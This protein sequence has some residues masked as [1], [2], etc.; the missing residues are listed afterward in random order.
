MPAKNSTL[1][2]PP[3]SWVSG[4]FQKTY[5]TANFPPKQSPF[6]MLVHTILSQ[7]TNDKNSG[8]AFQELQQTIPVTP[9]NILNTPLTE[10]QRLIK[11]AGLWRIK[12]QRIVEVARIVN[13][14]YNGCLEQLFTEP[15]ERIREGLLQFPGIGYKTADILLLFY[16]H[17][18]VLPLDVHCL[19]VTKRLGYGNGKNYEATRA[20]LE[21]G[22]SSDPEVYF[23][24]HTGLIQHGR[25]ICHARSP[26]CSRCPL[27][28]KCL[29]FPIVQP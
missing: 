29:S 17:L 7:H 24:F 5:G 23:Q 22:L 10:L 26:K 14:Q 12:S 8:R 28:T 11:S 9:Q 1:S 16:A 4:K 25:Q 21:Q 18:P 15:L 20:R 6:A 3:L 19:R 27:Q 2:A 13:E